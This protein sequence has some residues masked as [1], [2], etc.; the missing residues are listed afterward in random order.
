MMSGI[1]ESAYSPRLI[2]PL[3]DKMCGNMDGPRVMDE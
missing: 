3:N 1:A 2:R